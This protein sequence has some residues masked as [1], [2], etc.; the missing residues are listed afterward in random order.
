LGQGFPEHP[1]HSGSE[2]GLRTWENRR[3]YFFGAIFGEKPDFPGDFQRSNITMW[4]ILGLK[5][6]H[7]R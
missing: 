4:N 7:K 1:E 3:K 2:S 5:F 6:F